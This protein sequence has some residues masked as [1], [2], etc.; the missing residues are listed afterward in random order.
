M[1]QVWVSSA[2]TSQFPLHPTGCAARMAFIRTVLLAI[3]SGALLLP[4]PGHAQSVPE[5]AARGRLSDGELRARAR[6]AGIGARPGRSGEARR[7]ANC[8]GQH[9][10]RARSAGRGDRHRLRGRDARVPER[11]GAAGRRPDA[12]LPSVQRAGEETVVTILRF[13]AA[14]EGDIRTVVRRFD[15]GDVTAAA[16]DAVPVDAA[17][18]VRPA[19][20]E[21]GAGRAATRR[22]ARDQRAGRRSRAS[23]PGRARGRDRCRCRADR[24]RR[25]VR[26]GEP[27]KRGRL[28]AHACARQHRG[29][30]RDQA[31]RESQAPGHARE[32]RFRC[33]RRRSRRSA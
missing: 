22:A 13:D 31:A 7:S 25:R 24:D 26:D 15:G 32:H 14:G 21:R 2:C 4:V 28:R 8:A 6:R 16:L 29:R 20:A 30:R 10:A 17:R 33:G 18:A 5:S 11:D 1:L 9:A 3:V 19:R 23:V 12:D 27:T